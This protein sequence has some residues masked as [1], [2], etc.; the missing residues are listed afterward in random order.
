VSR[1]EQSQTYCNAALDGSGSPFCTE[2][3]EQAK[4][5]ISNNIIRL[6]LNALKDKLAWLGNRLEGCPVN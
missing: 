6:F 3:D 1:N 4:P 5:S 2:P